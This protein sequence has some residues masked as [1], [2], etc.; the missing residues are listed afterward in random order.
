[1]SYFGYQKRDKEDILD[2]GSIVKDVSL[3][4]EAA[5]ADRLKRIKELQEY[6]DK[7]RKEMK[8]WEPGEDRNLN[9]MVLRSSQDI[10]AT[11]N[12]WEKQRKQG[13]IT[14]NE[15]KAR[16][17]NL[18]T[19]WGMLANTTQ[20]YGAVVEEVNKM[21]ED[22]E[23]SAFGLF[24]NDQ[25]ARLLDLPNS[26]FETDD[27]GNVWLASYN[28]DGSVSSKKDVRQLSNQYNVIDKKYDLDTDVDAMV[29][30]WQP[31]L[32]EDPNR[33]LEDIALNPAY[34][35]NKISVISSIVS[36][37]RN[38][39]SILTER[40]GEQFRF[41]TSKEDKDDQVRSVVD[42]QAQTA[43]FLGTPMT[44]EQKDQLKSEVEDRMI[45]VVETPNGQ[46]EPK[47]TNNQ[48]EMA[49]N[50]VSSA[51]DIRFGAKDIKK[52]PKR[53]T[54]TTTGDDKNKQKNGSLKSRLKEAWNL[55]NTKNS[56][57][58]PKSKEQQRE[59]AIESAGILTALSTKKYQYSW[60]KG[61]LYYTTDAREEKD[62]KGNI[63]KTA[64]W[65]G[66][67]T[68]LRDAAGDF[69]G[70]SGAKGVAGAMAAYDADVSKDKPHGYE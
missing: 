43:K 13:I 59:D 19:N 18:Q 10:V 51:I 24:M 11:I 52:D 36:S 58:T 57:G 62:E 44:N 70:E 35:E 16:V 65:H 27:R 4:L 47:L 5:Q 68:N 34:D 37:E 54:T 26:S 15:Y 40:S 66:P 41:Y 49:A 8:D 14:P 12:D 17:D 69:Y 21:V 56:D 33:K 61:G 23:M 60:R 9:D 29:E 67:I 46:Y 50:V 45:Q 38:A 63:I 28:Q 55:A 42:L 6:D 20:N 53:Y 1:M 64:N 7:L 32:K 39:T 22:G 25:N 31:Y 2:I 30:S 3:G 48:K